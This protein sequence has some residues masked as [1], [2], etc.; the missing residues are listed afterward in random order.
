MKKNPYIHHFGVT[1][2]N[3][4]CR[5]AESTRIWRCQCKKLGG[6]S[7]QS[8]AP[9]RVDI[10][11]WEEEKELRNKH[12]RGWE[13][14]GQKKGFGSVGMGEIPNHLHHDPRSSEKGRPLKKAKVRS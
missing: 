13:E 5:S 4:S 10:G 1:E 14:V 8:P 9:L 7:H 6:L 3:R 11:I 2:S 12:G